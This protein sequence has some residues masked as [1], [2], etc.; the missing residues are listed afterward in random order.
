MQKEKLLYLKEVAAKVRLLSVEAIFNAKS[1][2]PGGSLSVTDILTYLYFDKMNVSADKK[3]D[4]NR[5]RFVLSKGHACPAL[6]S[7]L[8]IKGYFDEKSLV[9]LRKKDSFLQG[10]PD[11]HRIPGI[12]MSTGSLGQGISAACG[13]AASAKTFG[14]DYKVYTVLGDGEIQEGQ[15]WE[16]A[17]FAAHYKLDKLT[18]FVDYNGLQIDGDVHQVMNVA[19]V[20]E[21]FKAFGWHTQVIDGHDFEAIEKAVSEAEKTDKPSV[22]ICKTVK[23]KGVSFMENDAGWH[24][25]APNAEQYEVALAELKKAYEDA[26]EARING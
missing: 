24:G 19:P 22:I 17:M 6:Y 18:A 5:D 13:I 8:A 12:D 2:H 11:M 23:G 7:A 9:T 3:N 10:H 15:V 4:P 26:K 14:K 25:K 21:K 20:D 1:G 16:A